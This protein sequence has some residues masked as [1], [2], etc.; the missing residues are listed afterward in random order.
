MFAAGMPWNLV[1]TLVGLAGLCCGLMQLKNPDKNYTAMIVSLTAAT[2]LIGV[3]A[4]GL[5][6]WSAV[7]SVDLAADPLKA[8]AT[9]GVGGGYAASALA[10]GALMSTISALVGGFA[11]HRSSS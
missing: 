4:Y 11:I 3:T 10:W 2:F 7:G 8:A 1:T 9:M 6:L 5:G